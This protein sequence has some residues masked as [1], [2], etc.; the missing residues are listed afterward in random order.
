MAKRSQPLL[1]TRC[2]I[3]A[4]SSPREQTAPKYV[5]NEGVTHCSQEVRGSPF[6]QI[7]ASSYLRPQS[8]HYSRRNFLVH[9]PFLICN[10]SCNNLDGQLTLLFNPLLSCQAE[11]QL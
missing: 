8:H 9:H 3:W 4:K 6:R 5:Q 2:Y 11:E 10:H 1:N 7:Q